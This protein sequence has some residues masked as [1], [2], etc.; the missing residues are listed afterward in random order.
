MK[1]A[2][3]TMPTGVG[4][5]ITFADIAAR[6][7]R[8][9]NR[10]LM[11]AH[12][13]ELLQQS[14]DKFRRHAPELNVGIER[15]D[16]KASSWDDIVC[17]SVQTV[18]RNVGRIPGEYGMLIVDECFPAGTLVSGCPIESLSEGDMV[19]CYD[20]AIGLVIKMPVVR[21][22]KSI[23]SAIARVVFNDG[24][25]LACTPGHP[26]WD[27]SKYVEACLLNGGSMVYSQTDEH[28]A[29]LLALRKNCCQPIQ[30]AKRFVQ[31]TAKNLLRSRV[32]TRG[33]VGTVKPNNGPNQPSLCVATNDRKEPNEKAR[34][35][36]KNESDITKAWTWAVRARRQWQR[37]NA[38]GTS[39]AWGTWPARVH[40]TTYS[41]DTRTTRIGLPDTLQARFRT[42]RPQTLRRNRWEL[43]LSA[44]SEGSGPKEN[45]IFGLKRVAR[46][47]I[48]ESTG[49]RTFGG[50][51]PDGFVYNIEVAA[52]HNYFAGGVLVHNCHHAAATTY[53][54]IMEALGCY[55]PGGP[56]T[57]GFTATLHRMDNKPLHG[58]DRPIFE[59]VAYTY[60]LRD[61]IRDGWLVDVAGHRAKTQ[62]DLSDVQTRGGDY[63][64]GQLASKVNTPERNRAAITAWKN[65]CQDARTIVFCADVAH[66]DEMARMFRAAG[67]SSA[68]L[69][70]GLDMDVRNK[71]V[72]DFRKGAIQVLCNVEVATEGFDVPEIGCV[73]MARPTKSWALYVQMA[74]RGTRPLTGV[75]EGA[76]DAQTRRNAIQASAKGICHVI[77]M[78]DNSGTHDLVTVPAL[79]G[80][81]NRLDLQGKTVTAAADLLDQVGAASALIG[82]VQPDTF[83]EIQVA[84]ERVDLLG[85]IQVPP[86]VER[87]SKYRWLPAATGEFV[88]SLSQ[89]GPYRR[90]SAK[91]HEDAIGEW[92]LS[93]TGVNEANETETL[94]ATACGHDLR[95]AIQRSDRSIVSMFPDIGRLVGKHQQWRNDGPTDKQRAML[96]RFGYT[97]Q[98]VDQLTKGQASDV[99]TAR[100]SR[101]GA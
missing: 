3:I 95:D 92:W 18:G 74:G 87:A 78:V 94:M 41:S 72:A 52:H 2:V 62:T 9:G 80:L 29:N 42:S 50:L 58:G 61:A 64:Q 69:T 37:R 44:F 90:C 53:Q 14:A 48:Y 17:A 97:D 83:E 21:T 54:N 47:E 66:S 10:V 15:G 68:S 27:G 22:F 5:T 99:I 30:I 79:L 96:K 60:S 7:A 20:H 13:D 98:A 26:F 45:T 65:V 36:R 89:S 85:G 75:L 67:F 1:R 6:E 63:V 59:R 28:H 4:K 33:N 49:D 39:Y 88:L 31:A 46:V 16:S 32:P 91:L 34:N 35:C 93:V 73:L 43:P 24:T 86:E 84:I 38:N 23:P 82:F 12:R 25:W 51:C 70:G 71:M 100:L 101:A 76:E 55:E 81:P 11:V 40:R 56:T 57:V 19:D 8:K 77:D